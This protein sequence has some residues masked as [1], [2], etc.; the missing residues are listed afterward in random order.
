METYKKND[1]AG[2]QGHSNGVHILTIPFPASGHILPH[3]DLIHQL[4]LRG[5]TVTILV[6]PKNLHYLN[7][8]LSLHSSI[9]LQTLVLPF[10]SHSSIP[11]GV[12]N[13]QD[14]T[15]SFAPDFVT[16]LS[17]L[18]DPLVQWFKA[19]PYP[20]VA[21]LSDMLLSSWVN[22]LASHLNIPNLSFS[23]LN[24]NSLFPWMIKG[25]KVMDDAF[26]TRVH[27]GSVGSWGLIFNTFTELDGDKMNMIKEEFTKHDRLWA[28]GPLLPIK[29]SGKTSN[30]RGGPSSIPQDQVMAWLDSCQVDKSVVYVGFGTQ[31][32]LTKL[33]MEAVASALEESG[34]RF[35]WAVKDPM[36]GKQNGDDQNVVPPGFEQRVAGR[37][38]VIKGWTPQLAILEH[39]AVGSYLTHC[40]WNSAVE[41]LLGGVL[42]LAWPMQV[43]HFDNA[44]LLVDE[45]GVAIRAC[46]GLDSV[47]DATKLARILADS[48]SMDRVERV[49]AMQ[50]RETALAAIQKGGSSDK[51]L[52][53]LVKEL[54]SLNATNIKA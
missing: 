17:Q 3:M 39:R 49:R 29:A 32:T 6:T 42:L 18:Y 40:G 52:N 30:E 11:P 50:L 20:P 36:K 37:G 19:H 38:L 15:L 5:L 46:E 44:K 31:I 35:I 14:V 26:S 9:N 28:V 41:G 48:V 43:D 24:A 45:L 51:A 34:V 16:A 54:C 25:L 27:L 2:M 10:P 21:I 47:P 4:L 1:A 13:M 12:E 8:L 53:H 7:P 22:S 33:Q 23:V